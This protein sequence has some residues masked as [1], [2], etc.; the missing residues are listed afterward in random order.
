[1]TTFLSL[2]SYSRILT[3]KKHTKF[4][5]RVNSEEN[6]S[7]LNCLLALESWHSV[8]SANT[9]NDSY[10]ALIDIFMRHYNLF[11][12]IKE[13]KCKKHDKAWITNSLN[14]ACKKMN[15]LY[16]ALKKNSTYQNECRYKIYK[17]KLTNI[18]R[19]CEKT[20]Y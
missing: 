7:K 12:P 3:K 19:I 8:F 17:N 16:V 2:V 6:I 9:V 20:Y 14:G 11:C 10:N 5:L 13:H 1:M 15:K 4:Y 18:P